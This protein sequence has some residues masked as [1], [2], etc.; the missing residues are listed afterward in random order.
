MIMTP[1]QA[2]VFKKK[3]D[4]DLA[5]SVPG[6]GRFRCNIFMQR[7]TIGLVFRVIPLR[8]P[9][10]EELNLPEVIKKIAMEQERPNSCNRHYRE[11]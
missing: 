7:G 6:L 3:N 11:W 10:I 5:Y 8:I 2:E 1:G 9:T 4:I